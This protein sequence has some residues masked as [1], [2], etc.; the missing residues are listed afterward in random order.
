[1]LGIKNWL[2]FDDLSKLK[3]TSLEHQTEL[4]KKVF[5]IKEVTNSGV[6]WVSNTQIPNTFKVTNSEWKHGVFV[7]DYGIIVLGKERF[8]EQ[9]NIARESSGFDYI[10]GMENGEYFCY[11]LIDFWCII[12]ICDE[13]WNNLFSSKREVLAMVEKYRT[14]RMIASSIFDG[15]L[16]K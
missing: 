15:V 5:G 9:I 14:K 12:P 16:K 11:E 8:F 10:T 6:N 3:W 7:K 2:N 4:L 13:S 1:M